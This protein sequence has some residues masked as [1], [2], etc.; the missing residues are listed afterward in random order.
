[1]K[2]DLSGTIKSRKKLYYGKSAC[3]GITKAD[4]N[5]FQIYLSELALKDGYIFSETMLHELLHLWFFIINSSLKT[6]PISETKQHEVL[7]QVIP[8]ILNHT[9]LMLEKV[10]KKNEKIKN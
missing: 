6:K 1:M 3:Y 7:E 2:I 4:K 9:R 10:G 8:V 5:K